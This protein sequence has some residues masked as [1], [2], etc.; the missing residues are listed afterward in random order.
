MICEK[1]E[2]ST[3]DFTKDT[4]ELIKEGDFIKANGTTLGADNGI[5]VAVMLAILDAK[6]LKGPKIECIFT[7]QEETTMIGAKLIDVNQRERTRNTFRK[8]TQNSLHNH[9]Y[10]DRKSIKNMR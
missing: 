6:D 2:W 9:V 10:S 3:H 5:G 8:K 7:V 4:I 1:E